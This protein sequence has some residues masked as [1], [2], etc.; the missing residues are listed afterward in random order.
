MSE[1]IAYEK[2]PVTPER[3]AELR[4]QGFRIVDIR[5]A[6][7]YFKPHEIPQEVITAQQIDKMRKAELLKRLAECGIQAPQKVA[8]M[9][10][11]LKAFLISEDRPPLGEIIGEGCY[12]AVF[13]HAEDPALVVKLEKVKGANA[14]EWDVWQAVKGTEY[15][16]HFATLVEIGEG[17]MTQ[18]RADEYHGKAPA[19]VPDIC[20]KDADRRNFGLIGGKLVCIDM[21]E[22]D[23]AEVGQKLRFRRV[24]W[25]Q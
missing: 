25:R 24:T 21:G 13:A 3:K 23:P 8:D 9:R 5:F 14:R 19:Q 18:V 10:V 1:K 2:H 12:R 15:E 4:A 11:A 17:W 7:A 16:P 20:S 6:P 22:I